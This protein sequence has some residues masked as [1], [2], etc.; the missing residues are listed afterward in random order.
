MILVQRWL[1]QVVCLV[2]ASCSAFADGKIFARVAAVPVITPDQRA[3]LYF[4]N[5]VE[6]LV[7]ETSFIGEGTNFAWVVPLPS[8]PNIEAV[9]TNF[10]GYL[11]M[12][13]QPELILAAPD[14]WILFLVIGYL[15]TISIYDTATLT[16]ADGRAIL[17]WLP[18]YLRSIQCGFLTLIRP[19]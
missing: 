4:S 17:D 8:A 14:W 7:V 6:R 18:A 2:L 10:F 19:G 9:S 1:L 12:A 11:N 5:G 3:M 15:A 16:S 13:Y